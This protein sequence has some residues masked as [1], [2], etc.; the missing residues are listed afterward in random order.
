MK[1]LL[2]TIVA[3]LP[4]VA[5]AQIYPGFVPGQTLSA[6]QLNQA[7]AQAVNLSGSY[8]SGDLSVNNLTVRGTFTPASGSLPV[9][10]L[11]PQA[12]NTAVANVTGGV[13]SPAAVPLPSCS[14]VSSAL[15]YASG[16]GFQCTTTVAKTDQANSFTQAQTITE[17]ANGNNTLQ[18]V[19]TGS[20]GVSIHMTGNGVTTP[21]KYLRVVNGGFLIANDANNAS[22]F[23]VSDAGV[24]ASTGGLNFTPVGNTSPSTGSFT[25]LTATGT[26]TMTGL[27]PLTALAP[28]AS[29]TLPLNATASS[30]TPTA[31]A[32]PNCNGTNNRLNYQSNVGFVCG[33][34]TALTTGTLAQFA[35]TTSA[36]LA[37]V[38]SDETG[39]GA[40][41]F[42]TSPTL[43]TPVLGTP[44]SVTLTNGTGLP[45]S[46]GVSG[47]GTGV[48]TG[49]ASA[50]TGT[51]G[52]V[53]ATSPTITTP[54]VV[55]S[56]S[57]TN[58]ASGNWGNVVTSTS[59]LTSISNLTSTNVTSISLG[60]GNWYVFGNILYAAA[61]TTTLN[62]WQAAIT[63][64]SATSPGN[65]LLAIFNGVTTTANATPTIEAPARVL[66]LASTT[67]VYL[68][69]FVSFNVSTCQVQGVITAIRLP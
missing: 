57:G 27:I 52:P 15:Q 60:P 53:L 50:A 37:G 39:S 40:L 5:G 7:F 45:I 58:P 34:S 17:P 67:T 49:L 46:T 9:S 12:A 59:T 30:A 19:N 55:G 44:T 11:A 51:G 25:N 14:S 6:S 3:A 43:T 38:I 35:A 65:P 2:A 26:V 66:N 63:T 1:K 68:Y 28:I 24:I 16:T 20:N 56:T 64:V 10:S 48:A 13:A 47:L 31:F 18:V 54:T 62:G 23:S 36:Q 4:L 32:M 21:T 22:I 69:G 42:G 41:V 61:A 8:M 29:N 33:S